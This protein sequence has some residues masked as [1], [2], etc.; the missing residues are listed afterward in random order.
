[1]VTPVIHGLQD[2]RDWILYRL[3]LNMFQLT[4]V[5]NRI[6]SNSCIS[7]LRQV[8]TKNHVGE[9]KNY[10]LQFALFSR[11]FWDPGLWKM[12]VLNFRIS[13]YPETQFAEMLR[14]WKVAQ[15][16]VYC[17]KHLAKP[18]WPAPTHSFSSLLATSSMGTTTLVVMWTWLPISLIKGNVNEMSSIISPFGAFMNAYTWKYVHLNLRLFYY[19]VAQHTKLMLKINTK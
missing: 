17:M 4:I 18:T 6:Y 7:V 11:N 14:V 2:Y 10:G 5:D 3:L 9:Y 8:V 15:M 13:P 12:W 1:M 16:S 19:K